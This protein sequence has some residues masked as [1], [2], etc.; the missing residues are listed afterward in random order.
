MST[1]HK[2]DKTGNKKIKKA[3]TEAAKL[4]DIPRAA[5]H[6]GLVYD[7]DERITEMFWVT[8]WELFPDTSVFDRFGFC[9]GC[10]AFYFDDLVFGKENEG[11]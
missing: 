5:F 1:K 6:N 7:H 2:H 9:H 3:I 11:H 8:V 4:C 10:Q